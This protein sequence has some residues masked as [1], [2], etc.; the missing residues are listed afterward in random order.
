M[1]RSCPNSVC[2]KLMMPHFIST[3][4]SEEKAPLPSPICAFGT[5][6]VASKTGKQKLDCGFCSEL[7]WST[8]F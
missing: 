5:E 8:A 4:N 6:T 7:N 3:T 2:M 1:T